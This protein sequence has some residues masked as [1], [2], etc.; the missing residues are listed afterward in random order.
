[1]TNKPTTH[2]V[3]W[4]ESQRR[5]IERRGCNLAVSA[6]AGTGKTAVLTARV[7]RLIAEEGGSLER[8][9]IITFTEKAARQM[10]ERIEL[11]IRE[12][13]IEHPDNSH[14]RRA[15]EDLPAAWIM[16]IDAFCNRL[17]NEYFHEAGAAPGARIPDR[18]EE[19][20]METEEL[21]GVFERWAGAESSKRGALDRLLRC[22]GRGEADLMDD[23][24]H[25]MHFM[26]SL[27][28]PERWLER[29][30]NDLQ[31]TLDAESYVELPEVTVGRD[32]FR[33]ETRELADAL[34]RLIEQARAIDGKATCLETWTAL[35]QRMEGW[36]A[37][38]ELFVHFDA[39]HQQVL[40]DLDSALLKIMNKNQCGPVLFADKAFVARELKPFAKHYERWRDRLFA[41]DAEGWFTGERLAAQQSMALLDLA[42]AAVAATDT[43]KRRRGWMTFNDLERLAY[44]VL[45]DPFGSEG[46][47]AVAHQ[48]RERFDHVMVDEYQDTSPLQDA[49]VGRVARID[50]P[51]PGAEGNLFIVGDVKQSI[52]RFRHAEPALFQEKIGAFEHVALGDNFRSR[53]SILSFVNDCFARLMDREVGELDYDEAARLKPW[54]EEK[55]QNEGGGD[56]VRVEVCWMAKKNEASQNDAPQH[57]G[58]D[59]EETEEALDGVAAQAAWVARRI[60]ELTDPQSGLIVPDDDGGASHRARPGDCAILLRGLSNERDVWLQ[61]LEREGLAVHTPGLS[62]LLSA[63]ELIELLC[64]LRVADNPFQDIELAACMRSPMGGF[65]DDDL[66]DLRLPHPGGAFHE[67]VFAVAD[68]TNPDNT[69]SDELRTKLDRF[70]ARLGRWRTL[71]STSGPLEAL[72]AI[73]R[74]T[75]E[76]AWLMGRPD[77]LERL[78]H[79]DFLRD[80]MRRLGRCDE[81][82]NPLARFLEMVERARLAEEEVGEMPQEAVDREDAVHLLTMHKAK[83][84]E[85]PIVFVARLERNYRARKHSDT[86]LDIQGGMAR[87]GVDVERRRRYPTLSHGRLGETMRRKERAEELRLL[88]VAM[89][90]ARE[91]LV[92][93]GQFNDPDRLGERWATVC[94]LDGAAAGALDR[95][96]ARCPAD[97]IGPIV[98]WLRETS[99]PD[100]LRVS[101]AP[102]L[103]AATQ[104][105]DTSKLLAAFSSNVEHPDRGWAAVRD[106]I[107]EAPSDVSSP[108]EALEEWVGKSSR[109]NFL[110]A[111]DPAGLLTTL[112][113]KTTVTQL[114]RGREEF[115]IDEEGDPAE[116]ERFIEQ[117][118]RQP[119]FRREGE[120][121]LRAPVWTDTGPGAPGS[122]DAARRGTL[123]HQLLAQV[124]LRGALDADGLRAQAAERFQQGLLGQPGEAIEAILATLDFESIAW[125]FGTDVGRELVRR[126]TF[127]LRELPFTTRKAIGDF[128]PQAAAAFPTE[129]ILVQGIVDL[130]IDEGD[131]R[132]TV[133]DYKTDRVWNADRLEQL[134]VR[135]GLQIE[136][137]ARALQAI[138]QLKRVRMGLVFLDA[139]QIVWSEESTLSYYSEC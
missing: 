97:L 92:L 32:A 127:A 118:M 86:L 139:R 4:T 101:A 21:A 74:D 82:T 41:L 91:R 96:N 9:L 75:D 98:E 42:E 53:P 27:D 67:A 106:A 1:M 36:A 123:T 136:Q 38:N 71:A 14:L 29:A 34:R 104:P 57:D 22:Y 3:Q 114:R 128:A 17:I 122:I 116:I 84:L 69:L 99:A 31:A 26:Q 23:L 115:Q 18:A 137:Y 111:C 43:A 39:L 16:T 48:L 52:Y 76:E 132:A 68:S 55:D 66:I 25:T 112:P 11:R 6:S 44:G 124:D 133:L 50:D 77:A 113:A 70:M 90:R 89:T 105:M 46:P 79:L 5:A 117:E 95:L 64:A 40:D 13:L 83:G 45:T 28:R 35:A 130:V 61:A 33:C 30:R 81:G 47:S 63:P 87:V 2:T 108:A 138:W 121:V 49:I 80:L 72:D 102:P 7:L 126:P 119:Y 37:D 20:E 19:S 15:I 135:Y 120:T 10:R 73:L 109:L 103:A 8:M 134:A 51:T 24:R 58:E 62:P 85:F 78:R 93:V 129:T 131:G 107:A 94:N 60:R 88:Y 100:W 12:G 125:F 59:D 110:P 65:S 54:R 56:P